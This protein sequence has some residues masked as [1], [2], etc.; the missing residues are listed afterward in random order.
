MV[1]ILTRIIKG[2]NMSLL[3][4][5]SAAVIIYGVWLYLVLM[6]GAD[7]KEYITWLQYALGVLA[8]GHVIM[9]SLATALSNRISALNPAAPALPAPQVT[10]TPTKE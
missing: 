3:A 10:S 5:F 8:A 2:I 4:R 7:M 6:H 9:P 1:K